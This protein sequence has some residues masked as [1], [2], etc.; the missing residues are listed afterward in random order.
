MDIERGQLPPPP[1][2]V[3]CENIKLRNIRRLGDEYKMT[4][5]LISILVIAIFIIFLLSFTVFA[6]SINPNF[7]PKWIGSIQR[8]TQI[9]LIF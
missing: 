1:N 8:L 5:S 3:Q 7:Q 2:Y 6:L 4:R 9:E